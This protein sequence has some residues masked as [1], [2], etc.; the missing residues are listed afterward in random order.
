[1]KNKKENLDYFK[2]QNKAKEILED[3]RLDMII[4]VRPPNELKEQLDDLYLETDNGKKRK[5]VIKTFKQKFKSMPKAEQEKILSKNEIWI[6]DDMSKW[7][8]EKD[9]I[10]LTVDSDFYDVMNETYPYQPDWETI[11]KE[12]DNVGCFIHMLGHP[13]AHEVVCLKDN[14]LKLE[15]EFEKELQNSRKKSDE[16][17]VL[18]DQAEMEHNT[19][20]A[21]EIRNEL[22][23]VINERKS[24][25]EKDPK[26]KYYNKKIKPFGKYTSE[27][28]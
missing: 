2:R 24:I 18:L 6:K 16:L 14:E 27:S 26:T 17:I 8:G 10:G 3:M 22:R 9:A 23:N 1:M 15:K 4:N 13:S 7:G 25:E 21:E 11:H 28:D 5:Q 19:I 12:L 20:K